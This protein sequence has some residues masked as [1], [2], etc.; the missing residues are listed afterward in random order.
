MKASVLFITAG[1]IFTQ[2]TSVAQDR[3]TTNGTPGNVS[4]RD[5]RKRVVPGIKVGVD[6]SNV[7][8]TRGNA[9]VSKNQKQG[10]AAGVF[11]ALPINR[12][13]GIQPEVVYQQKGFEGSGQIFGERY[14]F[15]RTTNHIDI[16]VQFQLKIFKWLT[17]LAGPQYSILLNHNDN[18]SY[19][20]GNGAR[21]TN[22][23]N[24]SPRKGTFGTLTGF[25]LNFGHIVFSG[26]SGWDVTNNASDDMS[27]APNYKNRWIQGT[28]GY[29]FY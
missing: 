15:S 3:S 22:V 20:D 17:F 9:F 1:L 4:S 6:R 24:D 25:D 12:F 5:A 21:M 10:L 26:R 29:R 18:T 23:R 27:A 14:V 11:I 13:F 7:Y 8:D 2:L 16:P 19:V 28:V